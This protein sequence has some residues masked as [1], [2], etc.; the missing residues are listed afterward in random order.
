MRT[1]T[2][3]HS[4]PEQLFSMLEP[5]AS[6]RAVGPAASGTPSGGHISGVQEDTAREARGRYEEASRCSTSCDSA[7]R[8]RLPGRLLVRP[9]VGV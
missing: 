9:S 1:P 8:P 5:L 4:R 7:R 2:A 3:V 6:I